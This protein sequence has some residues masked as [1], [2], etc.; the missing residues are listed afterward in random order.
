MSAHDQTAAIEK[1]HK[2][3]N[4]FAVFIS[5]AVLTAILTAI[6]MSS[7]S[8]FIDWPR[9]TLNSIYLLVAVAKAV[10]VAMFYMHLKYD[11]FLY[12]VLFGV[13]VVFAIVFFIL[14]LV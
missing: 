9:A 8:G 7:Q 2:H 6:E 10:L 11:S 4:Y 3:P 1:P 13:P 14:I 5:L 12:T